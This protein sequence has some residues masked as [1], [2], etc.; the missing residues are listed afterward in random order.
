MYI[1]AYVYMHIC[2]YVYVYMHI[3]IFFC[4]YVYLTSHRLK[5]TR[6]AKAGFLRTKLKAQ[7]GPRL[8][9]SCSSRAG[10]AQAQQKQEKAYTEFSPVLFSLGNTCSRRVM[11]G[12]CSH[13]PKVCRRSVF[14]L[15]KPSACCRSVGTQ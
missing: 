13:C 9:R 1:C 3:Y 2:I 6:S 10:V 11:E 4:E 7:E 12:D 15:V 5:A 14:T 8:R